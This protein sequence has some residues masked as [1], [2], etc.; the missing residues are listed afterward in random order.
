MSIR[1]RPRAFA[2]A[3]TAAVCCSLALAACSSEESGPQPIAPVFVIGVDGFEWTVIRDLMEDGGM[4]NVRALMER[5]SWGHL[6]TI[7]PTLSPIIWNTIATG[8]T[9]RD[10]G[11]LSF[12]DDS[13]DD[14]TTAE[15]EGD[16]YTSTQ[17][18]VRAVWNIAHEHGLSSN[19]V[20]WWTTWPVDQI[21][22]VMVSGTSSGEFADVNWKP[23]LMPEAPHQV[24]PPEREDDVFILSETVG[25]PDVIGPQA[26]HIFGALHS[27]HFGMVEETILIPET[28]WSVQSDKTFFE[29][30]NTLLSEGL[31][32]LNMV[33]F[34]GPDVS[35][36][37]FWR[38]YEPDVYNWPNN[39][40]IDAWA[41][42]ALGALDDDRS[43]ADV[44]ADE[45]GTA[46][47]AGVIPRYYEWVDTMIGE[48]VATVGDDTT[49][50]L[51]SDHGMRASSTE[52]PNGKFVTGHH[53]QSRDPRT[54]RP[55]GPEA[56]NG[57]I[58]AAGPGIQKQGG[59]DAFLR[60]GSLPTHGSVMNVT[61]TIL[62]LL[63]IPRSRAMESAYTV[64]MTP[65]ARENASM[66]AV[67]SHDEGFRAP[68]RVEVDAAV[69]ESLR[70][71][72]EEI[73][74]FDEDVVGQQNVNGLIADEPEDPEE[75]LEED[76]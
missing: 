21:D 39:P 38:Y 64:F 65:E 19:V 58:L 69:S 75:D 12:I 29:I 71:R 14:P 74:Y 63:G 67:P 16:V 70:K 59:I 18:K 72:M 61:P 66:R 17:R 53:I 22:G 37:R 56:P 9:G 23:T 20:G 25:A 57:T 3:L 26:Q 4:P 40:A 15:V 46:M 30:S 55:V 2:A 42:K 7:E 8:R 48:L 45:E 73:G 13:T 41:R 60:N 1:S 32:D 44:L 11:I 35:G 34:G 68:H 27:E 50:L 49:I 47:L 31:S 5:G 28:M 62:A 52:R 24:W 54:G 6:Q 10:H 51:L 76:R 36:H 43:L 33:Y